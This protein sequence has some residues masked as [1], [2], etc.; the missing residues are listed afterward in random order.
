MSPASKR[1]DRI[2]TVLF[3]F[4]ATF[5]F[6]SAVSVAYLITKETITLNEAV[7]LKRA[8]LAAAGREV[9]PGSQ[10]LEALFR[11]CVVQ[12]GETEAGIK[13]FGIVEPDSG[14][15]EGYVFI[16]RGAGLWGTIVAVIGFE[17]DLKSIR[18]VE[19]IRHNE[20]PGLGARITEDWFKSQFR[21]KRGP[22]TMVPEGE[23]SKENEF[24]AITGATVTSTAVRDILNR[25]IANAPAIVKENGE[26]Q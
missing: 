7:F 15:L 23:P 18:G 6:S 13:Y 10:E 5:V 4:A 3:M 12:H 21:G 9:P 22:F 24:D 14:A 26:A 20:T 16:E 1:R 8:V 2:F 25:A 11:S 19:F 17:P